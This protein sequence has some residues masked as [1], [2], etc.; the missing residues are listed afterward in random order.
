MEELA[1]GNARAGSLMKYDTVAKETQEQTN[2]KQNAGAISF[3]S[4]AGLSAYSQR[5]LLR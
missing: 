5:P 3:P 2:N 1:T 4:A